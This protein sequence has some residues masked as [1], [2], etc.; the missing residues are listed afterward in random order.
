MLKKTLLCLTV[1]ASF[2]VFAENI[3]LPKPL[4]KGGI[5]LREALNSRRTIRNFKSEKLTTS[6]LSNIL[7]SANGVNRENGKR[8]APS[9]MDK[10]DV[11]IYVV[12]EDGSYFYDPEKHTLSLVCSGDLRAFCGRY[13]APCYLVLVPDRARQ[14]REVFA[15]VDTGYVSQNIYLSA[16]ADGLGTCAMGSIADPAKLVEK[17]KLG[18]NRPFLVH[19]VGIPQ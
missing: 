7:W 2:A 15:A 3:R 6:Q 9:A 4:R 17:L 12:L 1:L 16:V 5:T 13:D 11:M 14:V 19:P 18:K 10:R 8:T